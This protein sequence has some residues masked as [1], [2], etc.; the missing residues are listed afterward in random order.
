MP[1][2][3]AKG[4]ASLAQPLNGERTITRGT[5]VKKLSTGKEMTTNQGATVPFPLVGDVAQLKL[6]SRIQPPGGG[7]AKGG[8]RPA[9]AAGGVPSRV[10]GA[11]EEEG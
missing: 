10:A 3:A 2:L 8:L 5:R 7:Q 1:A 4:S 6:A 9:S 11:T